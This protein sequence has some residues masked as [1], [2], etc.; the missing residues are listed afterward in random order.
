[1]AFEY[2]KAHPMLGT[3][4]TSNRP[5]AARFNRRAPRRIGQ[6][7]VTLIELMVGIT[8]GLMVIAVS[9]GALMV[10]RGVSGSVSDASNIQQQAAYVMRS[11]GQQ[12][13]QAGSLY[14]NTTP[15]TG[16]VATDPLT[17]VAFETDA[18][19]PTGI[20]FEQAKTILG[21]TTT[22]APTVTYRRYKDPVFAAATPQS[23][24]RNCLGGPSDD[25]PSVDE[26]ITSTFQLSGIQLECGGNGAA[27]QAIIQNAAEFQITYLEQVLTPTGSAIKPVKA[28]TVTNWRAV[29]GVEVCLVLYGTEAIDMPSPS[30]YKDCSNTDV[31]M[32]ALA[33]PR[34]NR[35]HM[36]FRN[37]FQLRSQGLI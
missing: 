24:A 4:Q 18:N 11:I 36:V 23:S 34:R 35:M 12:L 20:S 2:T 28:A 22:G 17:A 25:G 37:V 7:G 30:N 33:G 3:Y 1:M 29:Q 27:A 5:V 13:R 6:R 32:T 16:A 21:D 10:S 14:V 26:A 9:M 8:I 31:D 19:S 15:V